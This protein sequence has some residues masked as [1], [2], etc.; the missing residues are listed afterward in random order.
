MTLSILKRSIVNRSILRAVWISLLLLTAS[1]ASMAQEPGGQGNVGT[2]I[3]NLGWQAGPS[4]GK[5]AGRATIAIP[6]K[7]VFL[8]ATDTSK[9]LTLMRNLP[10][11]DSYTFAPQDLNWFSIF[12]FEDTGYIKDDEKI[13]ADAVLQSLKEGNARGNEE[14]KKRGYPALNLDGWFVPPHY[15]TGTKRLE[16][17]TKLS[18]EGGTSVNYRIRILGRAGVMSAVLVSDPDSLDK[19]IRVFKT[20]LNDFSFD[21]GQKYSEYRPGDKIAEYGLTGLIIGGAAAAAAK[22]GLFKVIGKF[23]V[24]IFAGAV[25]MVGGLFKRLFG[26]RT[27]T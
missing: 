5:I 16:W 6:A 3:K 17:A 21:S 7:Y 8:G 2:Q 22:T 9:F 18:S 14:R 25:A 23:G 19:D 1:A 12:D 11:T 10:R 26:R 27:A 15:D 13:D 4:D 20:A 24:L